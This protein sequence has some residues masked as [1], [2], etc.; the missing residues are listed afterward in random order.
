MN[1]GKR[2]A[3]LKEGRSHNTGKDIITINDFWK[4]IY[5][6]IYTHTFEVCDQTLTPELYWLVLSVNL[7]HARVTGERGA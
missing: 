5:I 6:Y 4:S 3:K 2:R 7:I 1:N